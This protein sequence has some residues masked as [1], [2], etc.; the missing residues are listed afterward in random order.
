MW[1]HNTVWAADL[2]HIPP[3]TVGSCGVSLSSPA[4]PCIPITCELT[5]LINLKLTFVNPRP[6]H[7]I[8]RIFNIDILPRDSYGSMSCYIWRSVF[9]TGVMAACL[10]EVWDVKV[11]FMKSLFLSG[12]EQAV[13]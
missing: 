7:V 8:K 13:R 2:R 11:F 4:F 6:R 3:H 12:L 10:V 5:E 9:F 1:R